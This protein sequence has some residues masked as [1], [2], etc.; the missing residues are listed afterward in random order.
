MFGERQFWLG[1]E[2]AAVIDQ[3]LIGPRVDPQQIV[4]KPGRHPV[5]LANGATGRWVFPFGLT[6]WSNLA[7]DRIAIRKLFAFTDYSWRAYE[8]LIRPLGDEL[9]VKPAPGSGWPALSD[10]LRHINWAYVRW[11]AKEN[12]T[13]EEPPE[14]VTSWNQLE[15]YRDRVRG[16]ARTYF[17]A[18]SESELVTR[19]E[20]NVD[21]E[22]LVY[23]PA[24][25]LAN[26]L[27]HERQHHGDLNTLLYQLGL[28]VPIVEYRFSL[29]GH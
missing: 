7:V 21:G 29:P 24:D 26:V 3:G 1:M 18:L 15:S 8:G 27:L 22:T 20:M 6:V 19:R 10:A 9:L 28:E 16:R 12:G 11:L 14:A 23:S 17:D 2:M 13:T 25:I 4:F 5:I